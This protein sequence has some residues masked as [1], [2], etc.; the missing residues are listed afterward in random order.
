MF[1]Y[2]FCWGI[3]LCRK[4]NHSRRS[5]Q[6]GASNSLKIHFFIYQIIA[7]NVACIHNGRCV[8]GM[9]WDPATNLSKS[10]WNWSGTLTVPRCL[11]VI[12][13]PHSSKNTSHNFSALGGEF[14]PPRLQVNPVFCSFILY[15]GQVFWPW[16]IETCLRGPRWFHSGN[17]T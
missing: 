4:P 12:F 16:L 5:L 8:D 9:D 15:P 10:P 11:G 2:L 14:P 1:G 6:V 17:L 3:S 7:W 13:T